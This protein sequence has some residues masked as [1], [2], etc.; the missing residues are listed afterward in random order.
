MELIYLFR[1]SDFLFVIGS[2]RL[3][4]LVLSTL[5]PETREIACYMYKTIPKLGTED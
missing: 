1:Y 2:I 4:A 5:D 3:L